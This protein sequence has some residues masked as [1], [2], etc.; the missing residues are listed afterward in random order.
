LR[1]AGA[2]AAVLLASGSGAFAQSL[3]SR[4]GLP[5]Y[6]ATSTTSGAQ[7][8][9]TTRIFVSGRSIRTERPSP[10]GGGTLVVINSP[11]LNVVFD[12]NHPR[13]E[14]IQAPPR[15][16][17]RRNTAGIQIVE[18]RSGSDRVFI[19]RAVEDG[20]PI[21]LERA[22]CRADGIPLEQTVGSRR[23]GTVEMVTL[24]LSNVQAGPQPADLFRLP[25][26]FKVVAAPRR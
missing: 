3:C 21:E 26:G 2:A 8:S 24:T 22:R 25:P 19:A 20:R 23:G 17:A 12:T 1:L 11:G 9:A 5:S 6:S 4:I 15:P 10:Q 18:E 7:G 13:K 14:A 16:S